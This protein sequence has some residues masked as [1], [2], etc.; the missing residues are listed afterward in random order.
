MQGSALIRGQ[1]RKVAYGKS[2]K[3]PGKT[4]CLSVCHNFGALS[5]VNTY[6][7]DMLKSSVVLF[8]LNLDLYFLDLVMGETETLDVHDLGIFRT[9][10][11]PYSWI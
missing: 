4:T 6:E 1:P 7:K 11:N 3:K 8:C 2:Q 5:M 9:R 10:T